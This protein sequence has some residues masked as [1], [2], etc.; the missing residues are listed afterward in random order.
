MAHTEDNMSYVFTRKKSISQPS[1][2]I[3]EIKL[4]IK[5][6]WQ[7]SVHL[8]IRLRAL[9]FYEQILNEAQPSWLSLVENEGEKMSSNT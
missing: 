3:L 9:V 7:R 5:H 8:T 1:K 2:E 6:S 4:H